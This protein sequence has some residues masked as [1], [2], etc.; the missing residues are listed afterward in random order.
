MIF[1]RFFSEK[2][3]K[4]PSSLY[5]MKNFLGSKQITAD[6]RK[7]YWASSFFLD[8]VLDSYVTVAGLKMANLNDTSDKSSTLTAQSGG[9]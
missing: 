5:G 6:T 1:D 3:V 7:D 9:Q 4:E 8:K 2:T